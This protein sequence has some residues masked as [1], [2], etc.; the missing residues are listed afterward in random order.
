MTTMSNG[1]EVLNIH[2]LHCPRCGYLRQFSSQRCAEVAALQH[3][4]ST[5]SWSSATDAIRPATEQETP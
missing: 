4:C 1:V 3:Q 5:K 2:E